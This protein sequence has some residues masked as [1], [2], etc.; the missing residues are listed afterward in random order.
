MTLNPDYVDYVLEQLD[1]VGT[2]DHRKM[3]GGCGIWESGDIFAL[4]SSDSDLYFKV[5]DETRWRYEEAG[6]SQFRT[7]PY[8]SV[9][10]E[11]LEDREMFHEWARE[12]IATGHATAQR[13]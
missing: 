8:W 12:A 2:I 4:I 3:F 7:M 10:A 5:S 9:P 11:V 6:S 13:K 1:G